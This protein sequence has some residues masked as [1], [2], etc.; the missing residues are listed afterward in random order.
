MKG[1]F[2]KRNRAHAGTQEHNLRKLVLRS[3]SIHVLGFHLEEMSR[4][5]QSRE[6]DPQ[7]PRPAEGTGSDC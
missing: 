7:L 2:D 1:V 4:I 5:G 6:K 3:Q